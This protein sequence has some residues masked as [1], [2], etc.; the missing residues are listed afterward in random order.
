MTINKDVRSHT[1]SNISQPLEHVLV[2]AAEGV[3]RSFQQLQLDACTWILPADP[4]GALHS[5][6]R[7]HHLPLPPSLAVLL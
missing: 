2:A 1:I 6:E 4:A 5:P 7:D 3:V